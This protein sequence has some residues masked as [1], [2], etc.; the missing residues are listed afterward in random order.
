MPLPV[1][2]RASLV[3]VLVL[4]AS[5][6][7]ARPHPAPAR[8]PPLPPQAYAAYLRG[9]A[10]L[11]EG[12]AAAALA[13]FDDAAAAAPDE[14]GIAIGRAEAMDRLEL[15]ADATEAIDVATGRWPRSPE[16]WLAAGQL[17]RG[18]GDTKQAIAA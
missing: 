6:C 9:R 11:Y 2:V 15:R 12:D 17:H 1:P 13:A 3:A 5:G 16:V 10:A 8:L 14:A 18:A 7:Y 4:V